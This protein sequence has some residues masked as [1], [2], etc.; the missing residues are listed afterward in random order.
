MIDV[1]SKRCK[2]S[3]CDTIITNKYEGYCFRCFIYNFPESKIIKDFGTKESKVVD[4]IKENFSHLNPVFNK[5]TKSGRRPDVL[6]DCDTHIVII[7]I[8]ENQHKAIS[9]TPEL[10]LERINYLFED[11][12]QRPITFIRFN[13]DAYMKDGK[14]YPGCFKKESGL[15]K[16]NMTL[17]N[18]RFKKL[19]KAINRFTT[20]KQNHVITTCQ[21]Y[22]DE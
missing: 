13:P 15:S 12:N 4:F 8:D 22:F 10:E 16:A 14:K 2:T 11:F 17:L 6:I 5:T 7:E 18:T 20:I 1:V 3:D 21:L 19:T 9:Y